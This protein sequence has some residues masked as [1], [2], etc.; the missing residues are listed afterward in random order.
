MLFEGDQRS[1]K[2]C[3]KCSETSPNDQKTRII[4]LDM[5]KEPIKKM[6]MEEGRANLKRLNTTIEDLLAKF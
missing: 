5:D 1:L 2:T 4:T 6:P 3:L